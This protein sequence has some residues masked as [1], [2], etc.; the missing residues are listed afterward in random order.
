[1]GP[2]VLSI[3]VHAGHLLHRICNQEAE[4]CPRA[5]GSSMPRNSLCQNSATFSRK[6]FLQSLPGPLY[7]FTC[8]ASA[9]YNL[10]PEQARPQK[11]CFPAAG[12]GGVLSSCLRRTLVSQQDS[13]NRLCIFGVGIAASPDSQ[14]I[15]WL[16]QH[17]ARLGNRCVQSNSTHKETFHSVKR[18]GMSTAP[19]PLNSH[20]TQ[21]H[22]RAVQVLRLRWILPKWDVSVQHALYCPS[23]HEQNSSYSDTSG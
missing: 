7:I 15:S 14:G 8:E 3:A 9:G 5:T 17:P 21:E 18:F 6:H 1:M 13:C 16:H 4:A 2:V 12:G 19:E 10:N 23:L 20:T 22:P 11:T